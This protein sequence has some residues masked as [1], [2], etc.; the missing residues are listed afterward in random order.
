MQIIWGIQELRRY[1]GTKENPKYKKKKEGRK[2]FVWK[3]LRIG[4]WSMISTWILFYLVIEGSSIYWIIAIIHVILTFF[5]FVVSIIHLAKHKTKT[6]AIVSL[7]ISS[8]LILILI[9]YFFVGVFI[10]LSLDESGGI[11]IDENDSIEYE[12]FMGQS[13]FLS[14]DSYIDLIY[15]SDNPVNIY[16]VE[17][18]EYNR[19]ENAE[20]FYYIKRSLE[21]TSYSLTNSFL[22]TGTYYIIVEPVDKDVNYHIKLVAK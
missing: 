5:V 18:N 19:Y 4:F 15:T 10:G 11:I 22:E 20:D 14:Y 2:G 6:L 17:D 16:L 8:I 3:W 9:F 21:T 1:K 12:Y 7:V 13:F